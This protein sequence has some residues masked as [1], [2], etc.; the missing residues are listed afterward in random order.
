[1]PL[2]HGLFRKLHEH[3]AHPLAPE[4]IINGDLADF[5]PIIE[6]YNEDAANNPSGVVLCDNVRLRC[7]APQILF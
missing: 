4:C 1:M 3:P 2:A 6:E 5:C 7:F